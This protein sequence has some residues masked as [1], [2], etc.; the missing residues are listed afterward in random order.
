MSGSEDT[1]IVSYILSCK[2]G[3][4]FSVFQI[5]YYCNIVKLRSRVRLRLGNNRHGPGPSI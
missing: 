5:K 4:Y 3:Y 2:V 1:K